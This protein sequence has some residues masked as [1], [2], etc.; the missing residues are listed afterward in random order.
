ML[1][2]RDFWPTF[3]HKAEHPITRLFCYPGVTPRGFLDV[4]N[5]TIESV[6]RIQPTGKRREIPDG[7]CPCLYL[8]VQP[9]GAKSWAVRYRHAGKMS[10]LTLGRYPR[11]PLAEPASARKARLGR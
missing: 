9:S 2:F 11:I 1:D 4:A 3:S 8:V 6:E 10:K 7:A 5:L